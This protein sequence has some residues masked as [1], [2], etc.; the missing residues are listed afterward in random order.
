MHFG[1]VCW[2]ENCMR[3]SLVNVVH[4]CGR[5]Y[6]FLS[7]LRRVAGVWLECPDGDW[8]YIE[9]DCLVNALPFYMFS[10]IYV[11]INSWVS[12]NSPPISPLSA[13][14]SSS[15]LVF[16]N[17][18]GI[19]LTLRFILSMWT[20]PSSLPSTPTCRFCLFEMPTLRN[21]SLNIQQCCSQINE[22]YY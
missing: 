16:W 4:V 3:F 7:T 1:D 17:F 21:R 15:R 11:Y 22:Y 14:S 9:I 10:Y 2:C 20:A 13:S 18:A 12:Y 5:W 19:S 6:M 8:R